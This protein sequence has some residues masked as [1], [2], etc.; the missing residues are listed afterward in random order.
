[1]ED[2][3]KPKVAGIFP[4]AIGRV[5]RGFPGVRTSGVAGSV[6]KRAA[7]VGGSSAQLV[8]AS[9]EGCAFPV[10]AAYTMEVEVKPVEF[11]RPQGPPQA[12]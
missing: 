6:T 10:L 12:Q 4:P 7:P 3:A 5:G 1:M 11:E 9:C 8:P 2:G